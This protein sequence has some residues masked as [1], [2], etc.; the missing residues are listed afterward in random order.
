MKPCSK[1]RIPSTSRSRR[2]LPKTAE[3]KP[4][5]PKNP[6]AGKARAET[7]ED[8]PKPA[9][10]KAV[11]RPGVQRLPAQDRHRRLDLPHRPQRARRGGLAARPLSGDHQPRR[12]TGMAAQLRAPPRFHHAGISHRPLLRR[13]QRQG[14]HRP[15]RRRAWKPA[16]SRKASPSTPS[17]TPTSPPM[18]AAVKKEFDKEPL[19]LIFNFY[20]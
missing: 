15:V 20:F 11:E 1:D 13:N 10:A 7:A 9:V 16:R 12:R 14:A 17:A 8:Q 3:I 5:P 2:R 6:E 19:E 18:P 4:T